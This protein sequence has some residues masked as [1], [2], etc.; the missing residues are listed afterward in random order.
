MASKDSPTAGTG[1]LEGKL[2]YVNPQDP[3]FK[4]FMIGAL[5]NA[6][7]KKRLEQLYTT[8]QGMVLEP[9]E[10]WGAALNLLE[11]E[12]AYDQS[13]LDKIPDDGPVIFV[14]NHPF[15]VVDGL[16]LGHLASLVR[17]NFMMLVNEVLVR[18]DARLNQFLLPIDFQENKSALRTNIETRKVA[19]E[20]LRDGQA[21]VIF[22]SG[23]VATARKGGFGPVEELEWKRFTAKLI[24]QSQATVVPIYFHGKNSR[25]FQIAS[26]FGPT[27]RLGLLL[28]E[29]R[30]KRG[31]IIKVEVGDPISYAELKPLKDRE[32]LLDYL[33]MV[34]FSLAK[35]ARKS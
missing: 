23:G 18:Q 9:Q 27:L 25:I 34:T 10:V 15:G 28:N 32:A 7:G 8:L 12:L 1:F 21:L 6:T 11:V 33:R 30:N 31:R 17:P 13:Q 2:T 16:I 24:Q 3:P 4:R 5:E 26:Q 22:P 35:G 19:T 29:V 20:R 14:A